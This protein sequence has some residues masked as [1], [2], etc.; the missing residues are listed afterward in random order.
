MNIFST[1]V[2]VYDGVTDNKGKVICLGDFL[3][4][5]GYQ[6]EV[7]M[8]RHLTNKEERDAWKRKLP[9]ATVCGVFHP[10]RSIKNLQSR[11]GLICIDIDAKENPKISDWVNLKGKLTVIPQIAY[12]SL[13]VAEMVSL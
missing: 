7:Q 4:S 9:Q 2:S 12:C 5:N 13:S 10:T 6:Y 3:F 11:S 8:L 1:K